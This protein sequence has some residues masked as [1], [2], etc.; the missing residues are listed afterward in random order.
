MPRIP[1]VHGARE[2][3]EKPTSTLFRVVASHAKGPADTW[4]SRNKG[5]MVEP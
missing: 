1:K 3:N 2:S 5:A 4:H